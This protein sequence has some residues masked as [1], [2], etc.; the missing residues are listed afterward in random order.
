M[1]RLPVLRPR[2]GA[3]LPFVASAHGVNRVSSVTG[4]STRAVRTGPGKRSQRPFNVVASNAKG[5]KRPRPGPFGC[6]VLRV[7]P[8][9]PSC[10]RKRRRAGS[11]ASVRWFGSNPL[12]GRGPDARA[13][14][15]AQHGA[16]PHGRRWRQHARARTSS[17]GRS[18]TPLATL[19]QR[20]RDGVP[21][22]KAHQ[23][24]P[25]GS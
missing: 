21:V 18:R 24:F 7:R 14:C 23:S 6:Q 8:P 2:R 17:C 25:L 16:L 20:E 9:L 10:L 13:R 22:V 4:P 12:C 5:T 3:V 1:A 11:K 19:S 15:L